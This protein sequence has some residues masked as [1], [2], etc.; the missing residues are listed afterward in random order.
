MKSRKQ[1]CLELFHMEW[2]GK[3]GD[4]GGVGVDQLQ[5][6]EERGKGLPSLRLRILYAVR[7]RVR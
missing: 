2:R 5:S 7:N 6:L 1:D 3:V 4:G